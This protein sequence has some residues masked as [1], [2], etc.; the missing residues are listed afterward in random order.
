MLQEGYLEILAPTLDTPNA[1]RVRSHMA[2][3]RGVHLACFGTPDADFEH[4]RLAAHGF[5]PEP[6]VAL[7]RT[8]NTGESA[9]FKV[10]YVPP[11]KMPEGRVQYVEQLTPGQL[12]KKPFV[13]R[14][15]LKEVFVVAKNPARTAARW[16]EFA[17]LLPRAQGEM[18]RLDTARGSVL[19]ATRKTL[20][21]LLG[22]APPA[23]GIA[24]Y[25]LACK[26]PRAMAGRC[27]KAGLA[28]KRGGGGYVVR[29]PPAL[30]GTWLLLNAS[31]A[32]SSTPRSSRR[33]SSRR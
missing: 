28:V 19:V 16:A 5:E 25:S 26:D 6:V 20:S 33:A 15:S 22:N 9:R 27:R 1:R 18:V 10:V 32:S 4:Q 12:W 14:L 7:Q 30:G 23:P 11:R 21:R 17:G 3:Y 29:L 24:G 8:L 2:R 13:N 31:S